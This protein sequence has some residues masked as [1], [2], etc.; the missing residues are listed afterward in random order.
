MKK[1]KQPNF[2]YVYIITNLILEKQY[3]GSRLCYKDKIED[4]IYW[5]SSKYLNEDY[6][7]YGKEN[8]TKKILQSDYT[9]KNDMLDGETDY[10]FRYNTLEPNGYNRYLPNQK[11]GFWGGMK[12]KHHS[13]ES[14]KKMSK[15]RKG[16]KGKK[17]SPAHIL[18]LKKPKSKKHKQHLSESRK[19]SGLSKGKNN[20]MYGKTYMDIWIEKFGEEKAKE[21]NKNKSEKHKNYHPSKE[22]KNKT[23]NTMIL[24]RSTTNPIWN[25]GKTKE[26][27]KSVEK[28][29]K[30]RSKTMTGRS[31]S[32]LHKLHIK[33]SQKNKPKIL[34]PYCNKLCDNSSGYFTKYHGEKC[35]HKH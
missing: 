4:D 13:K 5:G 35:K 17:L 24:L 30:T 20:P 6:K 9:N 18:L 27:D 32:E 14:K 22:T 31:K 10:I 8:F 12:G 33:Q 19:R 21:L 11:K 34:C 16:K 25:K 1:K 28:S 23:S 7:I 2:Y 3:V 26:T 29:A 15:S